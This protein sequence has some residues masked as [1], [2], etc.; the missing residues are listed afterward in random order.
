MS[1]DSVGMCIRWGLHQIKGRRI[2]RAKSGPS[3]WLSLSLTPSI[4]VRNVGHKDGIRQ[5]DAPG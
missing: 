3:A 4:G 2:K 5:K 1:G